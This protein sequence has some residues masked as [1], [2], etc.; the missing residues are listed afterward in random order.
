MLFL[1][2]VAGDL[3]GLLFPE[4]CNGCG[5]QIL[6]G[7]EM[8]C[9]SCL[10]DL[11]YT[12]FHL[13][14]DNA[15]AKLFWGRIICG[16]AMAMLYFRKG[17]KV[18]Q[19]IHRLKYKNQPGLGLLLGRLLGERLLA[20]GNYTDTELIIPVP[21]HIRKERNRGYNQSK[22]IADGVA[23]VLGIPVADAQLIRHR[24]TTSQTGKGRYHR[25]E[26][27]RSVFSV[28]HPENINHKHILLV[29]DVVTTGST[30]EACG[31]TLLNCGIRKLS[32]VAV[33]CTA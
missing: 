19:L 9:T 2:Q 4:L 29:D 21:L 1:R 5:T 11:P 25:F 31:I 15:V 14:S 8:I 12:D 13:F 17:S 27:M 18:Q 6:R 7:E 30:L 3:F 26:N 32:I 33:A 28:P 20:S 23:L 16:H 24:E 10:Y 22:S